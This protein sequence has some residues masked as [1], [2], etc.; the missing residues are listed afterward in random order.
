MSRSAR[1]ADNGWWGT[2]LYVFVSALQG[3]L[4]V[5][6]ALLT[7]GAS[8]DQAHENGITP[9]LVAA[10]QGH[11]SVIS[12]LLQRGADPSTQ[13]TQDAY[14]NIPQGSTALSI[15]QHQGHADVV[16]LLTRKQRNEIDE[17]ETPDREGSTH[18]ISDTFTRF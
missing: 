6:H 2:S 15:A 17:R 13:T 3:H 4:D 10:W 9:L 12:V 8:V 18:G 5:V 14:G 16:A 1:F 7:A 11:A